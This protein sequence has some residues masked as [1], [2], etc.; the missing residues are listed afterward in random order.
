MAYPDTHKEKAYSW[1]NIVLILTCITMFAGSTYFFAYPN[2]A[3]RLIERLGLTH[4]VNDIIKIATDV[5]DENNNDYSNKEPER[6]LLTKEGELVTSTV[7]IAEPLLEEQEAEIFV[8]PNL[9]L[10]DES[11][12]LIL[13]AVEDFSEKPL[14]TNHLLKVDL[15]RSTIVFVDNFSRGDFIASFS[16]LL[17]PEER[18]KI[19]KSGDNTYV[20]VLNYHRYDI[21]MEYIDSIDSEKLV[22]TY[23]N[24]KPLIDQS[25]AEISLPGVDF[26]DVLND[27]IDMA[28]S[29]PIINGPIT[30]KSPSVMYLFN[31]PELEKLNDAQKLLLRIGATNLTK[32]QEKLKN[33]ESEL[34]K[35][36]QS[37]DSIE[38]DMLGQPSN[39][40]QEKVVTL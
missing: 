6:D 40:I 32:L 21:Y 35:V 12:P 25:Y 10:I 4:Y 27:A 33:I 19:K 37:N 23:R 31:N 39:G 13:T 15:L 16:P 18:F 14:I 20:S 7:V 2:S 28:L 1:L 36:E 5:I 22:Q 38:V 30:L 3:P 29:V 26:N 17:A 34:N 8:D 24:L 9:P 11:D